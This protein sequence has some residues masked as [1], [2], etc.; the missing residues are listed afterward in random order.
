MTQPIPVETLT[1]HLRNVEA[2]I[3]RCQ[4]EGGT[5]N[6]CMQLTKLQWQLLR[7]IGD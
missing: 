2:N 7:D 4:R 6:A 3:L 5:I 1:K